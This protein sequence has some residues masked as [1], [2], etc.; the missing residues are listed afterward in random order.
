MLAREIEEAIEHEDA[1]Y[2]NQLIDYDQITDS[3]IIKSK[4]LESINKT[5]L[6]NLKGIFS[7]ANQIIVQK[8][9][10]ANYQFL[11]A[12]DDYIIFRFVGPD[13]QLNY[14]QYQI[15]TTQNQWKI[16]DIYDFYTGES[17]QKTIRRSYFNEIA[18]LNLEPNTIKLL[19]IE[20]N[21]LI[22]LNRLNKAQLKFKMGEFKAA[23]TYLN[24]VNGRLKEEVFFL[25]QTILLTQE[26]ALSSHK[27]AIEKLLKKEPYKPSLN[28]LLM[29]AYMIQGQFENAL[30]C[31]DRLY[32]Y[33]P[34]K[35]LN[36][37]RSLIYLKK[38][39]YSK[40]KT[41]AEVF[42]KDFPQEIKWYFLRIEQLT[43]KN[44]FDLCISLLEELKKEFKIHKWVIDHKLQTNQYFIQT[45]EY[46][47]WLA[48]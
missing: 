16:K 47:A 14:H 6:S 25:I 30:K 15:Q 21:Y 41:L 28:L 12:K 33:I 24:A 34:D 42:R 17:F 10:G 5:F 1:N 23:Y 29:E 22:N 40:S 36:Y 48:N 38:G 37:Y 45:K 2:L 46:K 7:V 35:Y 26:N 31:L 32:A 3:I 9:R 8:K 39:N 44:N 11:L 4:E 20:P 19:N 18:E 27:L 13:G 43:L